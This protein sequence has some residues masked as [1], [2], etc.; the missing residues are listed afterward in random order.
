MYLF[1][2]LV[3]ETNR[4]GVAKNANFKETDMVEIDGFLSATLLMS[5]IV[6]P[7]IQDYWAH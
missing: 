2:L 3:T 4:Y 5:L 6:L 7:M 1:D